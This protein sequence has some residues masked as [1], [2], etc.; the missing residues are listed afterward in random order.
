[1]LKRWP[2]N[3]ELLFRELFR[4]PDL[5][6]FGEPVDPLL[7]HDRERRND[8]AQALRVYFAATYA[9]W[10]QLFVCPS[11]IRSFMLR[12]L[13]PSSSDK[14]HK[15]KRGVLPRFPAQSPALQAKQPS[16]RARPR[17]PWQVGGNSRPRSKLFVR[18]T[19]RG[20]MCR[21][22]RTSPWVHRRL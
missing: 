12:T 9:P 19:R 18:T 10:S 5:A 22:P 7:A 6:P 4:S 21:E 15:S 2:M 8:L 20:C 14:V 13:S 1:M 16:R 11:G 17:R 3:V